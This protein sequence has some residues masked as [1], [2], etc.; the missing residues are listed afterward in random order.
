MK[1]EILGPGCNKCNAL[2]ANA[3]TA[4]DGLGVDYTLEHVTDLAQ[5]ASYGVMIT[6]AI[7]VDGAVKSSGKVLEPDKIATLLKS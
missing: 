5:I 1:I 3:K 4:A 6:P 2:A 7:V